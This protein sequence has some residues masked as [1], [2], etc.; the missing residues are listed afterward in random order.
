M[1]PM[2]F[3]PVRDDALLIELRDLEHT[4]SVFDALTRHTVPGVNELVPGARTIL[5]C[6]RPS[7]ITPEQIVAIVEQLDLTSTGTP[8]APLV[9]IAVHY[10]G[11]DLADVARLLGRSPEE[12][13]DL[14]T[15]SHY[16]VGFTGFA[17]GFAY[18]TGGNPL[19]N[20]PR[21]DSP[22][23]RIPSGAVALGGTFSGIYPRQSPGGWQLIGSTD[24]PLWDLQRLLPALLQPGDRVR[25]IDVTGTARPPAREP[26]LEAVI[27]GEVP[28]LEVVTPGMLTVLEDLGRPGFAAMG[29]STSGAVDTVSLRTANHLLG[30][31]PGT[32]ALEVADGG[33]SVRARGEQVIAVTGAVTALIVT[34]TDGRSRIAP[35][36]APFALR[37]GEVLTLGTPAQGVRSYVAVRGG[38]DIDPV[39]GSLSTDLLAGLGPKALSKEMVLPVR[40]IARGV[41]TVALPESVNAGHNSGLFAHGSARA[42]L[43]AGTNAEPEIVTLDIVLG[44]RTD[45]FTPEAISALAGEQWTVTPES[46]RVGLRLAGKPIERIVRQDLPA[47]LPSEGT[48]CGALQIPPNGQPV[49]FLADHPL[50]GGYPVI[51][52]VA[53]YHLPR[54]AQLAAGTT[55]R[56]NPL[57]DFAEYPGGQSAGNS[58][59]VDRMS[60]SRAIR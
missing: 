60:P 46:N 59:V 25:F 21:R 24:A 33:L 37:S 35:F 5:V 49:L 8:P 15:G 26:E 17:P 23:T 19:L 12:I 41:A 7:A 54:A 40:A 56:F 9:E 6:Y 57:A 39:L 50:T 27:G 11:E 47:E 16:T 58:T 53:S 1:T 28:A 31:T 45:W 3:L 32:A 48:V 36:A 29:V 13:I 43:P 2:R 55:V 30:N 22:R 20:V 44:P 38:F 42:E 52:A 14:H 10:N 18:L 51:G 4:L 34:Q